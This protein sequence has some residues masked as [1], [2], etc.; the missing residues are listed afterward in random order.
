[1]NKLLPILGLV[2]YLQALLTAAV[3]ASGVYLIIRTYTWAA[4]NPELADDQFLG[5]GACILFGL[6][7]CLF[8]PV[9]CVSIL[10]ASG[11]RRLRWYAFC[12]VGAGFQTAYMSAIALLLLYLFGVFGLGWIVSSISVPC[13]VLGVVTFVLL[14][15]SQ[16]RADFSKARLAKIR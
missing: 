3:A 8:L 9:S 12:L 2:Y 6:L 15:Q 11:L 5:N 16:V 4:A 10:E 1:M 14:L 13:V 7:G